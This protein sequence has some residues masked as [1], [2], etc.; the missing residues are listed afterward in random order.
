MNLSKIVKVVSIVIGIVSVAAAVA[1]VVN[2]FLNKK[3]EDFCSY[4]ECEDEPE[5]EQAG[6]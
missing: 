5:L 1:A 3:D 4:I 6:V 2:Y